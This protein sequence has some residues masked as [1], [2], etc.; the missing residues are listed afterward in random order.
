MT[1][2]SPWTIGRLLKWTAD[3]L[4]EHGADSP[5]LDAEVLLAHA[6]GCQRIELYTR[7]D[8]VADDALRERF[9]DMVKRRAAGTPVAYLV[10]HRE[11]YSKSFRVTPDVLIPRPE[12]EFVM[13]GLL[14]LVKASPQPK[15]ARSLVDVG[16]GSGNLAIC[17][18]LQLPQLRITAVD[19]SEP[20]LS[21]ARSNA[22]QHGVA[23]RIRFIASDLLDAIDAAERFDFIIANPPYIGQNEKSALPR[24]V[25]DYEP[26]RALFAG[27]LGLDVLERLIAVAVTRLV[28]GGWL[29]SEFSPAQ[30]TDL[31]AIV[32][33]HPQL[34]HPQFV[35]DLTRRPR[36]I[37]VRRKP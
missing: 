33:R 25:V 18:A 20:A 1:E 3:Y 26:H 6:R 15:S 16:T 30:A 21:I 22:Q 34:E 32:A 2:T 13:V 12:T 28:P 37:K 24:D 14:D 27:E 29:L 23:D 10:G 36:V 35:D 9:R 7:Y 8:E 19:I 5:R 4:K 31:Q 11:F 17:A